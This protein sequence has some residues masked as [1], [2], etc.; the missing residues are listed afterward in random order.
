MTR[1]D[2]NAK[3]HKGYLILVPLSVYS[4]LLL[5]FELIDVK[6]LSI[7][8]SEGV[9]LQPIAEYDDPFVCLQ[10]KVDQKMPMPEEVIVNLGMLYAMLLGKAHE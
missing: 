9:V 7:P 3:R 1:T 5:N 2:I 6:M 8:Y 10:C 4:L